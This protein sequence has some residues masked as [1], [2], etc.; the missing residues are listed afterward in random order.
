MGIFERYLSLWVGLSII[1]GVVLGNFFPSVFQQVASWEYAHV[2][3]L[4]AVLIWLMIYPISF[5][6][7]L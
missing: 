1:V 6:P 3:L 2:N 5:L 4:I 7:K